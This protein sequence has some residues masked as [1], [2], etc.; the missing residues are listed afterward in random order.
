[1]LAALCLAT[2][3]QE[4]I[5]E[6]YDRSTLVF[7]PRNVRVVDLGA[8]EK[9][10]WTS[11]W[12][13]EGGLLDFEEQ[14]LVDGWFFWAEGRGRFE[15]DDETFG[16]A[17]A[18]L[19]AFAVWQ[20]GGTLE[21]RAQHVVTGDRLAWSLP[22]IDDAER[23]EVDEDAL[24]CGLTSCPRIVPIASTKSFLLQDTDYCERTTVELFRDG[25]FRRRADLAHG[26]LWVEPL[27]DVPRLAAIDDDCCWRFDDSKD[28][29][30]GEPGVRLR[31]NLE[32]L[33][34]D[35]RWG[36]E[37]RNGLEDSVLVQR[38]L[39]HAG[40]RWVGVIRRRPGQELRTCLGP[41]SPGAGPEGPTQWTLFAIDSLTGAVVASETVDP[42][43]PLGPAVE[44]YSPCLWCSGDVVVSEMD[45]SRGLQE[46]PWAW[47]FAVARPARSDADPAWDTRAI[48][49]R[50]PNRSDGASLVGKLSPTEALYEARETD[51][52]RPRWLVVRA[53][54][55]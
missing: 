30:F 47:R 11:L 45:P 54:R 48:A 53:P 28:S 22:A 42:D 41:A 12:L 7:E 16:C 40:R 23:D 31:G 46:T 32:D 29:T 10:E 14:P 24:F 13:P 20:N 17:D 38:D 35:P 18:L 36:E 33:S 52:D 5:E 51:V 8:P 25:T 9:E 2:C 6:P 55:R 49:V 34:D 19:L 50:G 15:D 39:I 21:L 3:L 26:A 27:A 44:S 4:A 1:M 43:G 37:I